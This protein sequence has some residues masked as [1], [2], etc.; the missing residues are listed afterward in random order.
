MIGAPFNTSGDGADLALHWEGAEKES[1][2][3]LLDILHRR[4]GSGS[5]VSGPRL[6]MG[7]LGK[8]AVSSLCHYQIICPQWHHSASL[9]AATA[10]REVRPE[11]DFQLSR[12][13]ADAAAADE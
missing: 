6:Y 11:H 3:G 7:R 12:R 8:G 5:R 10:R 4:L 1:L 2:E 9:N 13:A